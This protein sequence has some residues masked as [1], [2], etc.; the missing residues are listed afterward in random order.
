MSIAKASNYLLNVALEKNDV[1]LPLSG[2]AY[3]GQGERLRIEIPN[4]NLLG[5]SPF[6]GRQWIAYV[7]LFDPNAP[8]EAMLERT[9]FFVSR[10]EGGAVEIETTISDPNI[11]VFLSPIRHEA[12]DF[13]LR[14]G[15]GTLKTL[16]ELTQGR[17]FLTTLGAVLGKVMESEP[18]DFGSSISRSLLGEL[19]LDFTGKSPREIAESLLELN[20]N[21]SF[22]GISRFAE[23][24]LD[25]TLFRGLAS[26]ATGILPQLTVALKV[27]NLLAGLETPPDLKF[28]NLLSETSDDGTGAIALSIA[29]ADLER[30]R[31]DHNNE[32][33]DGRDLRHILCYHYQ[34]IKTRPAK[35]GW[36]SGDKPSLT[37]IEENEETQ[38]D[39]ISV[40]GDSFTFGPS[41]A[42]AAV[43]F[44]RPWE[45]E[46]GFK[47]SQV[48][49]AKVL[50]GGQLQISGFDELF[51]HSD[52]Q[53]IQIFGHVSFSRV[54]SNAFIAKRKP[55]V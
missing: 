43:P 35:L 28:Y 5:E 6:E 7:V 12:V 46:V 51:A 40:V 11:S 24:K 30:L 14:Q 10:L 27:I 23:D 1:N 42:L 45:I 4:T 26:L 41:L 47:K 13:V 3:V 20:G 48:L 19:G 15:A 55:Q 33:Q 49:R 54:R 9:T 34:S 8:A 44:S 21:V 38:A 50:D 52:S 2:C 32:G 31:F 39:T 22:E 29:P 17:R 16:A 53:T 36:V 25:E 18:L 37:L